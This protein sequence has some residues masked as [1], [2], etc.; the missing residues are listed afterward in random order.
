VKRAK[1]EDG[2]CS[3]TSKLSVM[4]IEVLFYSRLKMV[5]DMLLK[6]FPGSKRD[7]I[8]EL[9]LRQWRQMDYNSQDAFRSM[10]KNA[11]QYQSAVSGKTEAEEVPDRKSKYERSGYRAPENMAKRARD[12]LSS[13]KLVASRSSWPF[14]YTGASSGMSA[15]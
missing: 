14:N 11:D 5:R 3:P 13:D 2:I 8:T 15:I 9:A 4:D 6:Y 7:E 1:I 10:F 12:F